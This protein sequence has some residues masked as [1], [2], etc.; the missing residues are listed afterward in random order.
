MGDL[1]GF[2]EK[3][4]KKIFARF[5]VFILHKKWISSV[6]VCLYV[7]GINVYERIFPE[8]SVFEIKFHV[9]K[10]PKSV[11][12]CE[13]SWV[14]VWGEL[15]SEING[16]ISNRCTIFSPP[17]AYQDYYDSFFLFF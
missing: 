9:K 10:N 3:H 6:C 15:Q 14:C 8:S 2:E 16:N 11:C 5:S 1:F 4:E 12:S 7:C 17:V 13:G